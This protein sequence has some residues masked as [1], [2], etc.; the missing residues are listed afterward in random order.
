MRRAPAQ[1]TGTRV[2]HAATLSR[3]FV[4][5]FL[6]FLVGVMPHEKIPSHGRIFRG[7]SV[8]GRDLV[9]FRE[10]FGSRGK[11]VAAGFQQQHG[12][13]RFSKPRGKRAAART[14]TDDDIFV[15]ARWGGGLAHPVVGLPRLEGF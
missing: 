10:S 15:Y 2:K 1:R 8:E 6:P 9:V 3:V 12:M 11:R 7:K 5:F 13:A 14:R 4:I